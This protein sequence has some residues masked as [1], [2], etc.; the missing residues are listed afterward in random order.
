M[1]PR[2]SSPKRPAALYPRKIYPV[3]NERPWQPSEV[4]FAETEA[5]QAYGFDRPFPDTDRKVFLV[6]DFGARA[7]GQ[8][9]CTPAFYLALSAAKASG[10]PAEI[11][12]GRR[13]RYRIETDPILGPWLRKQV[14]G[15]R[16]PLQFSGQ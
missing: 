11:R 4:S 9:D 5:T 7:D 8:A 3:P 1:S 15:Y 2:G 10:R 12:F 13:G 6:D 14:R 16:A